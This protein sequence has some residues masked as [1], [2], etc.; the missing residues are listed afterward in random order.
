MQKATG[1]DQYDK[2]KQS[3]ERETEQNRIK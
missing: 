3:H 2:E 1:L